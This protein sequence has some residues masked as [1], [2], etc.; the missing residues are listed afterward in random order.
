M[1]LQIMMDV[2]KFVLD[3]TF[4]IKTLMAT[5]TWHPALGD[6]QSPGMTIGACAWMER[7]WHGYLPYLRRYGLHSAQQL[8]YG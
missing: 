8:I 4:V 6:P 7:E 1:P 3:N 5:E 2:I